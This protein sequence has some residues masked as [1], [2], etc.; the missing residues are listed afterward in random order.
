MV[1]AILSTDNTIFQ[2][3]IYVSKTQ[4]ITTV[5]INTSS[6]FTVNL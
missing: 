1:A 2:I 3:I 5:R 6:I 4:H